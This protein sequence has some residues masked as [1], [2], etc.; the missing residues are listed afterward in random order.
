MTY[1][2]SLKSVSF[3]IAVMCT[4][5][6]DAPGLVLTSTIQVGWARGGVDKSA[7]SASHHLT[8]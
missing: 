8:K 5:I 6:L 1:L 7:P 2:V 3:P 4:I